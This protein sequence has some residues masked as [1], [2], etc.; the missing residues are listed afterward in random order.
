[1]ES[2]EEEKDPTDV[3]LSSF[4]RGGSKKDRAMA[5]KGLHGATCMGPI[6]S[7]LAKSTPL[8]RLL[9]LFDTRDGQG[10]LDESDGMRESDVSALRDRLIE[11]AETFSAKPPSK[12]A[13]TVWTQ[14]L[15]NE[16]IEV[17]CDA[18]TTWAKTK[19]KMPAPADIA[20]ICAVRRSES[21]E[22][23]AAARKEEFAH[24]SA[25]IQSEIG[26]RELAKIRA[27]LG[28]GAPDL[29]AQLEREA[30]QHEADPL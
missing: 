12:P 7:D 1:M 3:G 28:M 26:R 22:S 16:P 24:G 13:L 10:Y 17:I 19:T 4:S 8:E 25:R 11:L 2:I 6:G 27:K 20:A 21:I 14:V 18:F 23:G 29:E 9:R 30:I 15:K 5:K